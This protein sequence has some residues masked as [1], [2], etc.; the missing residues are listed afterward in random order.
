MHDVIEKDRIKNLEF[1]PAR[2]NSV[3]VIK[4]LN[5]LDSSTE[6]SSLTGFKIKNKKAKKRRKV[7]P[8]K[9]KVFQN[10]RI[11]KSLEN[12]ADS[13]GKA[14][15]A[16]LAMITPEHEVGLK[17]RRDRVRKRVSFHDSI[18]TLAVSSGILAAILAT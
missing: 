18:M 2:K 3:P 17:R 8:L 5:Y 9:R 6:K 7:L 13:A 10:L 4:L 11:P 16:V 14:F 12:V 1:K 15:D